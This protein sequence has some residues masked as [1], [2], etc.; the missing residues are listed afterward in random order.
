MH[1]AS[2]EFECRILEVSLYRCRSGFRLYP[3]K[4]ITIHNFISYIHPGISRD[5]TMED[6]LNYK[7]CRTSL[8]TRLKLS[9][10]HFSLPSL[11]KKAY[12]SWIIMNQNISEKFSLFIPFILDRVIFRTRNQ[13][14]IH[15]SMYVESSWAN[16]TNLWLFTY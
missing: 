6:K 1:C 5:K 13:D 9:V 4:T 8:L 11:H 12:N 15:I 3:E 10:N 7:N 2:I 16:E 14:S